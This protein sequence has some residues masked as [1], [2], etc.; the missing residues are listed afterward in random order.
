[1]ENPSFLFTVDGAEADVRSLMCHFQ[2]DPYP[3]GIY[4]SLS[5]CDIDVISVTKDRFGVG[6]HQGIDE[7]KQSSFLAY[8]GPMISMKCGRINLCF[9]ANT[10]EELE[11]LGDAP[12]LKGV[13]SPHVQS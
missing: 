5:I 8:L 4:Y 13:C 6:H 2:K 1:M 9:W 3:G 11:V 12:L 7:A 10:I